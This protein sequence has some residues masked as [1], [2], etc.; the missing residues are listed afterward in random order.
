VEISKW[1]FNTKLMGNT[2][3]DG[4]ITILLSSRL[5]RHGIVLIDVVF[6]LLGLHNRKG[7]VFDSDGNTFGLTGILDAFKFKVSLLTH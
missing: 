6:C 7:I 2:S 5:S 1:I 3:S 4:I